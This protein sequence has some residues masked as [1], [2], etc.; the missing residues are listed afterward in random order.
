[1]KACRARASRQG[2]RNL[3]TACAEILQTL[4]TRESLRRSLH[5]MHE[6][7]CGNSVFLQLPFGQTE[8]PIVVVEPRWGEVSVFPQPLYRNTLGL[9]SARDSIVLDFRDCMYTYIIDISADPALASSE[10]HMLVDPAQGAE[11]SE[12]VHNVYSPQPHA[13]PATVA[14]AWTGWTGWNGASFPG[15]QQQLSVITSLLLPLLTLCEQPEASV[16]EANNRFDD[17]LDELYAL[18]YGSLCDQLIQAVDQYSTDGSVT[19]GSTDG[20]ASPVSEWGSPSGRYSFCLGGSVDS[21]GSDESLPCPLRCMDEYA[22]EQADQLQTTPLVPVFQPSQLAHIPWSDQAAAGLDSAFDCSAGLLF[23]DE[24][25]ANAATEST[26]TRVPT[27]SDEL[28]TEAKI[29]SE[30]DNCRSQD[31]SDDEV[32]HMPFIVD[33]AP[34]LL[35]PDATLLCEPASN[36]LRPAHQA[37][38]PEL[39]LTSFAAFLQREDVPPILPEEVPSLIRILLDKRS[40]DKVQPGVDSSRVLVARVRGWLPRIVAATAETYSRLGFHYKH[41][42][43]PQSWNKFSFEA[44]THGPHRCTAF[45]EKLKQDE[46]QK[47]ERDMLLVF[48][49]ASVDP[50]LQTAYHVNRWRPLPQPAVMTTATALEPKST[51]PLIVA[52]PIDTKVPK[53]IMPSTKDALWDAEVKSVQAVSVAPDPKASHV[54]IDP[55]PQQLMLS[56]RP[57]LGDAP[58]VPLSTAEA[59][60]PVATQPIKTPSPVTTAG[61]RETPVA[62]GTFVIAPLPAPAVEMFVAAASRVAPRS[63]SQPPYLRRTFSADHVARSASKVAAPPMEAVSSYEVWPSDVRYSGTLDGTFR[64]QS[65]PLDADEHSKEIYDRMMAEYQARER[66]KRRSSFAVGKR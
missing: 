7:G 6:V 60:T 1:M 50:M 17:V 54:P 46:S 8:A 22:R 9:G 19:S 16:E 36:L 39:S 3:C 56:R 15:A 66:N 59:A 20:F 12:D 65:H 23:A 10:D 47:V 26:T 61:S 41:T 2:I 18:G 48:S 33:S 31:N 49:L 24:E 5:V 53:K 40:V 57:Q 29:R 45:M 37:L 34:P 14:T 11:W 30:S 58:A 28:A 51:A 32:D 52:D 35:H 44:Q 64:R 63:P 25:M 42:E 55:L 4:Q 21:T 27:E 43:K 13:A 38:S 62:T